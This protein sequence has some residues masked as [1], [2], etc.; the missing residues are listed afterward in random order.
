M[1][2]CLTDIK[3]LI[4]TIGVTLYRPRRTG[5]RKRKSARGC[6][7]GPDLAVI[8][9]KVLVK[10]DK[11]IAGL[12]DTERPRRLGPKRAN[13]IREA[14]VL[15]KGKDDVRKYVVRREIKRGD[16]TF[17]KSPSIQRL[18]TEKRIRR[19]VVNKRIKKEKWVKSKETAIAYEKLLSK[20]L[21]E[22]KAAAKKASPE[23]TPAPAKTPAAPAKKAAAAPAKGAKAAPTKAAPAK[24]APAKAA[25]KATPAPAKAADKK[26]GKK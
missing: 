23:P 22:K 18:I 17:Y 14:F 15:R 7:C 11:D 8:A 24:A 2:L 9:L 21:K 12:T 20:Y 16:K 4:C 25:P 26:K 19:K 6:I 1:N 10:G 5:E 13:H 3:L